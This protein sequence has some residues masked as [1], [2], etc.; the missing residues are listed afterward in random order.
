M[1]AFGQVS[2]TLTDTWFKENGNRVI[3]YGV[4]PEN[5]SFEE[6]PNSRE[7]AAIERTAVGR[8][9]LRPKNNDTPQFRSP[10]PDLDELDPTHE[11]FLSFD[12]SLSP[13]DIDD[14]RPTCQEDLNVL[15]E[16]EKNWLEHHQ[17]ALTK[18]VFGQA[19]A[20][21]M[22][23]HSPTVQLHRKVLLEQQLYELH[24]DMDGKYIKLL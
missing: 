23:L 17:E 5:R 8:T 11:D 16:Y 12:E 13:E 4:D 18:H 24:K 14:L 22:G 10:R 19:S 1:D 7:V 21:Q 9:Y 6:D 20:V 2:L 3:S 15:R